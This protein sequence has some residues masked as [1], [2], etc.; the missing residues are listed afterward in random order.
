[1]CRKYRTLKEM[2]VM[3]APAKVATTDSPLNYLTPDQ[4]SV[5]E[6]LLAAVPAARQ[7]FD[8]GSVPSA[9]ALIRSS[10]ARLSGKVGITKEDF[11]A[12][13]NLAMPNKYSI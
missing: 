5:L 6:S 10:N 3:S 4:R 13:V 1:M 7:E 2:I 8:R 9:L 11:L 12:I